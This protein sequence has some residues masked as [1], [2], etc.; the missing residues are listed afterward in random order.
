[1]AVFWWRDAATTTEF[2]PDVRGKG[3][4]AMSTGESPLAYVHRCSFC[5]ALFPLLVA[6]V[7][8]SDEECGVVVGGGGVGIFLV[9]GLATTG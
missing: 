5:H 3:K 6:L 4:R 2:G 1:M 9:V 8:A 7:V